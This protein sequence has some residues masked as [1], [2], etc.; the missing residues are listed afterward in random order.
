MPG[1]ATPSGSA[2]NH[3]LYNY[4]TYRTM[5]GDIM[6]RFLDISGPYNWSGTTAAMIVQLVSSS[7]TVYANRTLYKTWGVKPAYVR[8]T[9]LNNAVSLR[10]RVKPD[11]YQGP[12]EYSAWIQFTSELSWG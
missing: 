2:P 8:L 10:M 1:Y 6:M 4:Y 7:G 5:G 9:H 12:Y 3:T 11:V